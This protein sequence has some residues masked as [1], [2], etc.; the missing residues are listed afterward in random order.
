MPCSRSRRAKLDN[1]NETK[2]M[3]GSKKGEKK[4]DALI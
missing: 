4:G 3:E 1:E 2:E